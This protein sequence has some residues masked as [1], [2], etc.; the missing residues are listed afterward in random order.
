MTLAHIAAPKLAVPL[1]HVLDGPLTIITGGQIKVDVG[2][3]STHLGEKALEEQ[4]HADRIDGG[5]AERIAHSRV[6]SR[7]AA[8]HQD[9]AFFGRYSTMSHT[10]RK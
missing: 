10:I 9:A 5:D 8:L 2:P 7:A 4:L 3:L 6:G 1:V